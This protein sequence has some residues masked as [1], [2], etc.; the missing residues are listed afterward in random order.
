M[1]FLMALMSASAQ[2]PTEKWPYYYDSFGY[3]V[4]RMTD[5][6]LLE[7]TSLNICITD[8][9]LHYI[10]VDGKIMAAKMLTV[11]SAR[12]GH[13]VWVR[14]GTRMMKV[15]AESEEAAVLGSYSVDQDKLEGT[16]I[17]Y[18]ISSKTASSQKLTTYAMSSA[19]M[20][21]M[22]LREAI[23][24]KNNGQELPVKSVKYLRA[25]KRVVQ[26]GKRYVLAIDGIDKAAANAF[27]KQNKIKWNNDESLLKVAEFLLQYE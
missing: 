11:F 3:G 25:G 20:I 18:G 12:I 13:D 15:L 16:D 2:E 8:E 26:A 21:N 14:V 6:T 17:G 22:D 24:Q 9:S 4:I 5:G 19:G 1:S 23:T 27:F 10:S 7:D